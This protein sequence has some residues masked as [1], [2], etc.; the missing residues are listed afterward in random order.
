[1]SDHQSRICP[2]K[3]S[4]TKTHHEEEKCMQHATVSYNYAENHRKARAA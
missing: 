3:G 1:M 4:L 2:T